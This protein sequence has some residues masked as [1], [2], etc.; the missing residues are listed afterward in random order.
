M[1]KMLETMVKSLVEEKE[2]VTITQ[3][4]GSSEKEISFEVKVATSD[5][6]RVIGKQGRVAK[7]IRTVMKAIAGREHKKV[8]MEFVS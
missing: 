5:M 4:E 3:T 2:A 8:V 7:A 6:G 1:E